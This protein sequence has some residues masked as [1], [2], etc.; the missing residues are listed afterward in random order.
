MKAVKA[1]TATITAKAGDKSAKCT[2]TVLPSFIAVTSVTLDKTTLGLVEGDQAVLT[3]TVSPDNATEPAVTWTTSNASV[4]TVE[5]GMVTAVK[6]GTAVITAKAGDKS[7]KCTVTVTAAFVPVTS[8]TLNKTTLEMTE[9]DEATL[10]ATV[11]PDNATDKTVTW[12]SSDATVATVTDGKVKALKAGSVTITA[13]AGEKSATCAI[14]VKAKVIPV[15]SITLDKTT[16]SLVAGDEATLIAT[17]KPDNAT[18]KTVTWTS[19]DPSVA[20]VADGKVHA[21]KLGIAVITA[22]AGDKTATCTVTVAAK[23]IPVTSIWL[24]KSEMELTEGDEGSVRRHGDGRQ[25][26]GPQAGHGHDH[27]EGGRQVG[28]VRR[29]RPGEGHPRDLHHAQRVEPLHGGRR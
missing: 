2:V 8:V 16:L 24:D 23:V 22:K 6:A 21:V 1:G 3:A 25:G 4:A 28:Q 19:S 18:D 5:D 15:T 20:T 14:T 27:R 12:T 13:T 11:K 17:V 29:H 7:A 9:G 10:T 26:E